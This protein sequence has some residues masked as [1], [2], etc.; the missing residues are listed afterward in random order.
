MNILTENFSRDHGVFKYFGTPT[1][2]TYTFGGGVCTMQK[3]TKSWHTAGIVTPMQIPLALG[4]FDRFR[5]EPLTNTVGDP[6]TA[7]DASFYHLGISLDRPPNDFDLS[8]Y[9][10]YV[11]GGHI[12]LQNGPNS[13]Q[14]FGPVQTD[15]IYT[16][17]C[18]PTDSNE[19]RVSVNGP[20]MPG[21]LGNIPGPFLGRQAAFVGH[22]YSIDTIRLTH[23]NRNSDT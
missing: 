16:L 23:F 15:R 5:F 19:L 2:V 14:D 6:G 3:L 7:A 18:E 13:M 10:I 12:W 20:G 22:F 8:P 9:G 21:F 1:D 4:D 17:M 11:N